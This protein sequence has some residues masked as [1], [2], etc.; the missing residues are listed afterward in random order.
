MDE[1]TH[2][3]E[4]A[5]EAWTEAVGL[6]ATFANEV[7]NR[8]PRD[9]Q[10]REIVEEALSQ[11]LAYRV[12][13]L[14]TLSDEALLCLSEADHRA[15]FFWVFF[16]RRSSVGKAH[17]ERSAR[18]ST[19]IEE[20]DTPP[21]TAMTSHE[22]GGVERPSESVV[23]VAWVR[24]LE[25]MTARANRP[26]LN[27]D[28]ATVARYYVHYDLA[29]PALH[30]S[31]RE[32]EAGWRGNLATDLGRSAGFVSDTIKKLHLAARIAIYLFIQLAPPGKAV[33]T[34]DWMPP[35]L[36]EVYRAR[37]SHLTSTQR[38]LL[39]NAMPCLV[40]NG[41]RHWVDV[42]ALAQNPGPGGPIPEPD[43]RD[44]LHLAE[45][46]Y[47]AHVPSQKAT[48]PRFRCVTLCALHRP[49]EI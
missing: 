28:E 45:A 38:K 37:A 47:A 22:P 7:R 20:H 40:G 36:D 49:Q 35:L 12:K 10:Q 30:E 15:L 32:I 41:G 33:L 8:L 17:V 46:I 4:M 14:A 44:G 9:G 42:A 24:L 13:K 6:L 16:N 25:T 21:D 27:P 18:E 39:E 2:A 23:T 31:D 34:R 29:I 43:A 5:S 1:D 48:P 19:F 26:R 3:M 11:T